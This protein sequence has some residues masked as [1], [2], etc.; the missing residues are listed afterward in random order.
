MKYYFAFV[1]VRREATVSEGV[2][3][4]FNTI[5]KGK[6]I[7]V[8]TN[9]YLAKKHAESMLVDDDDDGVLCLEDT[10]GFFLVYTLRAPHYRH[11]LNRELKNHFCV[12]A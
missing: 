8:H 9:S 4:I 5:L 3:Q 6:K 10:G 11:Y 12:I 1:T 7:T 2:E